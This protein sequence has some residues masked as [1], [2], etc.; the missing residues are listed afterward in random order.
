MKTVFPGMWISIIKIRWLWDH[1]DGLAQDCSNSSALAMELL[2]SCAKPSILS[3]YWTSLLWK[4]SIFI[5]RWTK[6]ISQPS[7]LYN[8]NPYTWKDGLY[9]ETG[10]GL[11]MQYRP[12][13]QGVAV[14]SQARRV[15]VAW[16]PQDTWAAGWTARWGPRGR[17]GCLPC[18]CGAPAAAGTAASATPS[19]A[20]G[21]ERWR[22]VSL[23]AHTHTHTGHTI[24]WW[25]WG[26]GS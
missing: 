14:A 11:Y 2:Q 10:P 8:G 26:T 18:S 24:Q 22:S 4:E 23:T 13:T 20:D 1:L 6:M 21:G 17:S 12:I 7:Y 16:V 25:M 3:L 9:T 5:L 19:P 15:A